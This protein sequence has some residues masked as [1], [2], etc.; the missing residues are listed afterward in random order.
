M[1]SRSLPA[2]PSPTGA[3]RAP[4]QAARALHPSPLLDTPTPQSPLTLPGE[5]SDM[6]VVTMATNET[7]LKDRQRGNRFEALVPP[8][9]ASLWRQRTTAAGREYSA[10]WHHHTWSHQTPFLHRT[11]APRAA[12]SPWPHSLR[13]QGSMGW[14]GAGGAEGGGAAAPQLYCDHF[15]SRDLGATSST[16][17]CSAGEC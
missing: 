4:G 12:H 1:Q 13:W 7:K 14:H 8:A 11:S 9:C 15:C 16:E 6:S 17:H 5:S 2:V 10:A 3:S